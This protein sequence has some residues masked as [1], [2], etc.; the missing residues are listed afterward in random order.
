MKRLP[1]TACLFALLAI[2]A[3]A[4]SFRQGSEPPVYKVAIGRAATEPGSVL[5]VLYDKRYD[6]YV[7]NGRL[8][9]P[10]SGWKVT[11]LAELV[12]LESDGPT[13]PL[14]FETNLEPLYVSI[15]RHANGGVARL[16]E[17]PGT[18]RMVDLRT[19]QESYVAI[20]IGGQQSTVPPAEDF[21]SR[22]TCRLFGV[23]LSFLAALGLAIHL[24]QRRSQAPDTVV[25][26]SVGPRLPKVGRQLLL[27][28]L[29]VFA[30]FPDAVLLGAGFRMNDQQW[31]TINQKKRTD[32]YP[33]PARNPGQLHQDW[34]TSGLNDTAGGQFQSE[35]AMEFIRHTLATK[36]SPY[37]NPY[38]MAGSLG[39]ETLVDLKLSAFTLAYALLGGG[40]HVYDMLTLLGFWM[41]VFFV[42]RLCEG[43]LR[44]HPLAAT[45]AAVLYLLNGFNTANL[46]SNVAQSY[47]FV[48]MCLLACF[49]LMESRT[50]VRV[51]AAAAAYMGLLSY[52]FLPTT[53][54]EGLA[55]V[56]CTTGFA[57]CA[58]WGGASK[59]RI[60]SRALG[61]QAL[62]GAI[63]LCG[64]AF[65]YLP[66]F[67]N[68]DVTGTLSAYRERIFYPA[69]F[70]G[71]LSI[72]SSSHF[73]ESYRAGNPE[74][75]T[76]GGNT[77]FHYSV[78]GLG[79]VASA[80]RR[81]E[82]RLRPL[83]FAAT[84]MAAVVFARDFG[85]PGVTWLV[86]HLPIVRNIGEQYTW[87]AISIPLTILAAI[88]TQNLLERKFSFIPQLV[89]IAI[90]VAGTV[91]LANSYGLRQSAAVCNPLATPCPIGS[92]G[93]I[94]ALSVVLL[95]SLWLVRRFPDLRFGLT[96]MLVMLMFLQLVVDAK[97]V[98]FARED[99]YDKPTSDVRFLQQHAGLD[100]T[101]TLGVYATAM[102]N[103]SAFQLQ[104]VTSLNPAPMPGY[105]QYFK[106]MTRNLP[107]EAHFSE[108]TSLAVPQPKATLD[109]YDWFLV[110]LLGVKYV[111]A[112]S[113]YATLFADAQAKG[114]PIV[115]VSKFT[116]IIE[117]PTAFPRAF[118][119]P[120]VLPTQGEVTLPPNLEAKDVVP[121]K[122]AMY[123][124]ASVILQGEAATPGTAVL[125]DNW[126]RNWQATV[127]GKTVDIGKVQGTFRG[128]PV[129]A[130]KFEIAMHYRPATL[131]LAL[132]LTSLA[133]LF[134]IAVPV[135]ALIRRWRFRGARLKAYPLPDPAEGQS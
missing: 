70:N 57:L 101:M 121:V 27:S 106:E 17:A 132:V 73:F 56:V 125:T 90:A 31:A 82:S 76:L 75:F 9:M 22:S 84:L 30:A 62:V 86:D 36:D 28:L 53:L 96:G 26:N 5:V 115:H 67:E 52:T 33:V 74:A 32:F 48:P 19:P 114:L 65:I 77:I 119:L 43:P 45:A 55:I 89:L 71:L 88:G 64:V 38:S 4:L 44:L 110:N 6:E 59:I 113:T 109:Y 18:Y 87:V 3:F 107:Q 108:F 8:L 49:R 15:I 93:L 104:E 99:I 133:W 124:N 116:K 97:E 122:I 91:L 85:I 78:I 60:L 25:V 12:R 130:G 72:F 41:G 112:P 117:N 118:F 79:L 103:G 54:L 2:L 47:V 95:A 29:L 100:R 35:P 42:F 98:R 127:N 7:S 16:E 14:R 58:D 135:A 61:L 120:G 66:F 40:S 34:Y 37:W 92:V 13:E 68:L 102:D 111:I 81:G 10:K 21:P 20:Q 11:R 80:F 131:P 123:R 129:Q 51:A 24:R 50:P 94:A 69:S 46:G 83:A 105:K 39:P 23:T 63:A 126:H 134:V 128:I 1:L